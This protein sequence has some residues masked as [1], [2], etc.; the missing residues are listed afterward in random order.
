MKAIPIS[1]VRKL[2][3]QH[4]AASVIVI[5]TDGENI[6]YTSYGYDRAMCSRT[7]EIADRLVAQAGVM[8]GESQTRYTLRQY[9]NDAMAGRES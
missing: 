7:R 5:F 6:G 4:D 3:K 8:Y 2:A 9:R 1:E